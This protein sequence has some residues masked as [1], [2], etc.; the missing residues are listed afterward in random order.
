MSVKKK[1]YQ[2]KEIQKNRKNNKYK[3]LIVVCLCLGIGWSTEISFKDIT[4]NM[5]KYKL[6]IVKKEDIEELP[7]SASSEVDS[8]TEDLTEELKEQSSDKNEKINDVEEEKPKSET[9]QKKESPKETT[10]DKID[11]ARQSIIQQ[12]GNEFRDVIYTGEQKF[13][14]G[15][16]YCFGINIGGEVGGDMSLLVDKTTYKAYESSVDG[17]FGE[18]RRD[19]YDVFTYDMALKKLQEELE[20]DEDRVFALEQELENA[21]IIDTAFKG[22]PGTGGR[23]YVTKDEILDYKGM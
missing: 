18:Y 22:Q 1:A 15:Q 17:Y 7:K 5:F 19:N 14:G 3:I 10:Q 21:Y 13:K 23:Y 8:I 4:S 6:A 12:C 11:K 9:A 2:Q 16:Y 20:Y